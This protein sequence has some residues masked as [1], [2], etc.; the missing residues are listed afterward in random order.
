MQ[1]KSEKVFF[2]I[3]SDNPR[4][5]PGNFEST[6][7]AYS[8]LN[9]LPAKP[10]ILD[11]GCGPGQ[12]TLDLA[13]LSDGY[14]HAIDNHE[15]F[16]KG[17]RKRV[18]ERGLYNRV[19]PNLGDM[20]SLHFEQQYFDIIWAEGSIYIIG[21]ERGLTQWKSYLKSGGYL[22]VTEITW[23]KSN[24]PKELVNFWEKDYPCMQDEKGNISYI[25]KANYRL[26][27]H[28]RLPAH[29]WWNNYY[30]HI[31]K[32]LPALRLKYKNDSEAIEVINSEQQEIELFRKYSDYYGYVFYVMQ[33]Q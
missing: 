19:Y 18:K 29:A 28:F 23:L 31:E 17:L 32:K 24:P 5:G 26:V 16:I 25:N 8:L 9:N 7:R 12:Q 10:T 11:V 14:I 1:S 4:E 13:T 6:K 33:N 2:E 30:N 15:P 21:F 3:H 22:A 20:A 27:D